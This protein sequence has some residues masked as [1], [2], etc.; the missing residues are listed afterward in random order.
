MTRIDR[1]FRFAAIN[2]RERVVGVNLSGLSS[3]G[4]MGRSAVKRRG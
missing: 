3:D 4:A 2:D 1:L